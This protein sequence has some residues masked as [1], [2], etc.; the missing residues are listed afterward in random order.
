MIFSVACFLGYLWS[1]YIVPETGKV[2]LEE[3]D[4]V[5]GSNAGADDIRLKH[6]VRD[7]PWVLLRAFDGDRM[8][9]R[10][11]TGLGYVNSRTRRRAEYSRRWARR[12][13]SDGI[14]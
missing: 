9:D 7:I 11:R 10:T 1:T 8:V 6:E 4:A 5:F 14:S 13:L 3:M 2:S 12:G